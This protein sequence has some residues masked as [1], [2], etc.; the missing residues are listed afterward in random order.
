MSVKKCRSQAKAIEGVEDQ[1]MPLGWGNLS[2]ALRI[3]GDLLVAVDV[4][5]WGGLLNAVALVLFLALL[6]HTAIL[7][8]QSG[9]LR[10][11]GKGRVKRR[12]NG[13]VGE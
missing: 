11:Q 13:K 10:G 3:G 1:R 4:R 7:G 12:T 9:F 6:I 2:L 8:R 5:R